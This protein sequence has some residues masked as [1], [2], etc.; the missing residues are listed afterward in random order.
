[1]ADLMIAKKHL[2][3]LATALN[4]MGSLTPPPSAKG[5]WVIVK[6]IPKVTAKAQEY[7]ADLKKWLD[8]VVTQ[9]DSGA[10][11]YA[12]HAETMRFEFKDQADAAH[13][14]E[15]QDETVTLDGV[16]QLTRAELGDCPITVAQ[17][18]ML[19]ESGFLE[20]SEPV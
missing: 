20:D 3:A 17:E 15:I 7:A 12:M 18:Y 4:A 14:A 6:A 13:F 9:D 19:V 16:R 2:N 1:M 8:S 10:P 11:L 5:R